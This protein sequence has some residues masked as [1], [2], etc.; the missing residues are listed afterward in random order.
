MS[1]KHFRIST[2]TPTVPT[3]WREADVV[4]R[5]AKGST[6]EAAESGDRVDLG[7]ILDGR[8]RA[9]GDHIFGTRPRSQRGWQSVSLMMSLRGAC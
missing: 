5:V 2:T 9:S 8:A 7:S 3:E 1:H 6:S 4:I